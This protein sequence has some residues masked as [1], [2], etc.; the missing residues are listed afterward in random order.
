MKDN[1]VAKSGLP[2]L[3]Y[4]AALMPGVVDWITEK[5]RLFT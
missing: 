5:K 1:T 4:P 3:K 2:M